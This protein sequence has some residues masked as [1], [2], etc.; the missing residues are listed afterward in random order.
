MKI[1]C[2]EYMHCGRELGGNKVK[3]YGVCPAVTFIAFNKT[4]G[5]YNGGRYCW[6]IAGTFPRSNARCSYASQLED[7]TQCDFYRLVQK[8]EGSNF[9]A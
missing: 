3:E 5:G 8:E 9:E 4:N 2:W 1:N 7:C 6:Q